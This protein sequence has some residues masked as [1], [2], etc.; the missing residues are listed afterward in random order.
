MTQYNPNYIKRGKKALLL[1]STAMHKELNIY[2]FRKSPVPIARWIA[3]LFPES[4]LFP[5]ISAAIVIGS[6][7]D[8][9]LIQ[10]PQMRILNPK[11]AYL[12]HHKFQGAEYDRLWEFGS[13]IGTQ[14]FTVILRTALAAGLQLPGWRMGG[15]KH[16]LPDRYSIHM[17][18]GLLVKASIRPN[19]PDL[20]P[21]NVYDE[22]IQDNMYIDA[23]VFANV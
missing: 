3:D 5:C 13:E 20:I 4:E 9:H 8:G 10:M 1:G 17:W 6:Q 19:R 11:S 14:K 18:A 22:I 15:Y 12:F 2:P 21:D 16:I 7:T 23:G